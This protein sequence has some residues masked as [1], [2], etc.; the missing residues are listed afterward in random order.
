MVRSGISYTILLK[1][2]YDYFE[3]E[4]Y[5]EYGLILVSETEELS[6]LKR[7]TLLNTIYLR[8]KLIY[9]F[10]IDL[11]NTTPSKNF[12]FYS[13]LKLPIMLNDK[14][15]INLKN[16]TIVLIHQDCVSKI[17]FKDINYYTYL[18][19][20]NIDDSVLSMKK[21][22]ESLTV[23]FKKLKERDK[24]NKNKNLIELI[25]YLNF[26][27]NKNLNNMVKI[28]KEDFNLLN[29]ID[30]IVCAN[31]YKKS[32]GSAYKN[33]AKRLLSLM[34][35]NDFCLCHG[36]IWEP[37]ILEDSNQKIKLIDFDKSLL[38]LK[39][40]DLTYYICMTFYRN[41]L[42]NIL[43]GEAIYDYNKL[44]ELIKEKMLKNN[45]E[46]DRNDVAGCVFAILI[47]KKIEIDLSKEKMNMDITMLTEIFK[48]YKVG[49]TK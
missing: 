22:K 21:E 25:S 49:F 33:I 16:G 38:F 14:I 13:I 10:C 7:S 39:S 27:Q 31:G 23:L 24:K 15:Y 18:Y 40:Y 44:I 4:E 11:I 3:C 26:H 9:H 32:V 34:D 30:Q 2:I 43:Y 12:K 35:V 45:Y 29:K 17:Y 1:K 37:N 19:S 36:D 46:A 28:K 41:R 6:C 5:S 42:N 8:L 48:L 20:L 47:L